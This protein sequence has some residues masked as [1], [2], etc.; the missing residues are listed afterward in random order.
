MY[1]IISISSLRSQ[2]SS[3]LRST[4]KRLLARSERTVCA[5]NVCW[6]AED[7]QRRNYTPPPAAWQGRYSPPQPPSARTLATLQLTSLWSDG[8]RWLLRRC[9]IY[10][11]IYADIRVQI[12]TLLCHARSTCAGSAHVF[13]HNLLS[14]LGK[15]RS[16]RL[17]II[18]IGEH[19]HY[20]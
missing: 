13:L 7:T 17:H 8:E 16:D 18:P 15:T 14:F 6:H 12:D 19:T 1:N 5:P 11:Y 9:N 4:N 2:T 3:V 20:S 10:I